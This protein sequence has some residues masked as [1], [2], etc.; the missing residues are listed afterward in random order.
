MFSSVRVR[1]TLWYVLVFGILLS[2]FSLAIYLALSKSLY[3]QLDHS[4]AST[5]K[6]ITNSFQHE[7]SE[8]DG[9]AA[10]GRGPRNAEKRARDNHGH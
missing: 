5:A 1:L 3:T 7:T 2:G 6:T 4:L 8:R 10:P 9:E